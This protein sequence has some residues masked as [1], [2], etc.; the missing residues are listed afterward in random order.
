MHSGG[1]REPRVQAVTVSAEI[2]E[3]EVTLHLQKLGDK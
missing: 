1:K 3:Y 2:N